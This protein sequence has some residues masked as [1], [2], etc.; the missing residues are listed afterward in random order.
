MITIG[1]IVITKS[2]QGYTQSPRPTG[3]IRTLKLPDFRS[4]SL[5]LSGTVGCSEWI[6][7]YAILGF[8][9]ALM[10]LASCIRLVAIPEHGLLQ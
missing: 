2:I 1:L 10:P 3:G 4:G 6:D 7:P 5:C 8:L 9:P